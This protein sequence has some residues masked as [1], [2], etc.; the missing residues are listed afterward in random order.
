V[1][2]LHPGIDH[3]RWDHSGNSPSLDVSASERILSCDDTGELRLWQRD[4]LGSTL[5]RKDVGCACFIGDSIALGT[6]EGKWLILSPTLEQKG[7]LPVADR[8]GP[9]EVIYREPRLATLATNGGPSEGCTIAL[10]EK[11]DSAW[12]VR[13]RFQ[14]P[15][16]LR[17]LDV[18]NSSRRIVCAG[19]DGEVRLFDF[20]GQ[21]VH[22]F[23]AHS[24]PIWSVRF[25]P[26]GDEFVTTSRD[27]TAV[28]WTVGGDRIVEFLGHLETVSMAIF[29]P[30]GDR[31]ATTSADATVRLWTRRGEPLAVLRGHRGQVWDV[32]F[33]NDG[34]RLTSGAYDRELRT[35]PVTIEELLRHAGELVKPGVD[36]R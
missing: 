11:Q 13:C 32:A 4:E 9:I 16:T 5:V 24:A 2:H 19:I 3:H 14:V 26:G 21:L 18:H 23:T 15:T 35:W 12:R 30:S 17:S 8:R 34:K 33:S 20:D 1:F 22:E 6:K 29:S 25:A 36:P 31:V 7:A 28:L 10:W 27:N